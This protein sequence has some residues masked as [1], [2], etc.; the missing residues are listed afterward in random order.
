MTYHRDYVFN[1]VATI[2]DSEFDDVKITSRREPVSKHFPLVYLHEMNR[3]R[4]YQY[5][6]LASDDDQWV[7]TFEAEVYTNDSNGNMDSA[8]GIMDIVEG[9]FKTLGYFMTFCQPIDNIDPLIVRINARFERQ[10]GAGDVIPKPPTPPSEE[11]PT[12]QTPTEQT[13]SSENQGEING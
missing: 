9:A 12:E 5:A 11:T 13:P 2:V 6:T 7:S 1:Y 4:P 3:T 8:F 10:L